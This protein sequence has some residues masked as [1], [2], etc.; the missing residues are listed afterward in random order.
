MSRRAAPVN[1][2][3]PPHRALAPRCHW[4]SAALRLPRLRGWR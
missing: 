4:A 2:G 1:R 3:V